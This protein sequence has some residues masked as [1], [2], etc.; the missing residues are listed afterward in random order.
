MH[1][2]RLSRTDEPVLI[3]EDNDIQRS[4]VGAPRRHVRGGGREGG[5]QDRANSLYF[6]S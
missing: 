4:P 2:I 1:G 6:N 3:Q 5:R